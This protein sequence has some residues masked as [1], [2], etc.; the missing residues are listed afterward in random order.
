MNRYIVKT[1]YYLYAGSD[2]E[3]KRVADKLAESQNKKYDDRCEVD[4]IYRQ[5]YGNTNPQKI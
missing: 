1:S 5:D 4:E 3:A 2:R